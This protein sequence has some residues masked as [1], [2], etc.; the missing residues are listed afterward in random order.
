MTS[1]T[2]PGAFTIDTDNCGTVDGTISGDFSG[3]VTL[4]VV[5]YCTNFFPDSV[6]FYRNDAI[7]TVGW[8]TG[9]G[10][11]GSPNVIM[12]DVFYI[13]QK[14]TN[15][16]ISGD[17]A[18]ALEFAPFFDWRFERTF[19]R[20]YLTPAD[21]GVPVT[22]AAAPYAFIGDGREPL[23]Q[24][25]AFRVV[26]DRYGVYTGTLGTP[27][28]GGSYVLQVTADTGERAQVALTLGDPASIAQRG[29]GP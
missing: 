29:C 24:H 14:A 18:V 15:G 9:N 3:Y 5:N 6:N 28:A 19:Y 23:G 2:S 4:D 1:F 8:D 7:A 22:A 11:P 26:T 10:G 25:Y 12:G 20:R 16:N 13:D 17:P 21:T 27:M